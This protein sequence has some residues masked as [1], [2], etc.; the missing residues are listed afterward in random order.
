[1]TATDLLS[2]LPKAVRRVR[3]TAREKYVWLS[4]LPSP[5]RS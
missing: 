5:A 1:L 2:S 4:E 3:A